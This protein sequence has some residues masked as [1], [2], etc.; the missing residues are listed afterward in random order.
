MYHEIH[1][2]PHVPIISCNFLPF[3]VHF[4]A[5]ELQQIAAEPKPAALKVPRLPEIRGTPAGLN[6][7]EA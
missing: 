7:I 1:F 6:M 3:R 2:L 5:S 4:Q